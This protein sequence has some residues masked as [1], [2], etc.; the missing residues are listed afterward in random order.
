MADRCSGSSAEN[1]GDLVYE[2]TFAAALRIGLAANVAHDM[3]RQV[4]ADIRR[5]RGGDRVYVPAPS[6]AD[7]D[8]RIIRALDQGDGVA[9]IAEREQV[10]RG[11]VYAI[12]KMM[13][14]SGRR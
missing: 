9:D 1:L 4:D 10:S 2:S 13:H 3:A 7:R 11:T 6:R 12:R 14:E 8:R 5:R